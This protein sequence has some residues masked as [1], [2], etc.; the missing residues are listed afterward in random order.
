MSVETK[1]RKEVVCSKDWNEN[2]SSDDID[3]INSELKRIG[4][5]TYISLYQHSD[6]FDVSSQ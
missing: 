2:W 4:S 3:E 6:G 1:I 5:N